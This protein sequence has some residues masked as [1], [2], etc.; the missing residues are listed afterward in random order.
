MLRSLFARWGRFRMSPLNSRGHC[1]EQVSW[2]PCMCVITADGCAA[3]VLAPDHPVAAA[4][5]YARIQYLR[6][7]KDDT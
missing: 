6:P 5:Q 2:K 7:R 4:T 3:T 1:W